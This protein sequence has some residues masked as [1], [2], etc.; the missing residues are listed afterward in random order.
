MSSITKKE[1]LLDDVQIGDQLCVFGGNKVL[2]A[3]TVTRRLKRYFEDSHG[4]RWRYDG[5]FIGS[6][7]WDRSR[8]DRA[9]AE[10]RGQLRRVADIDLIKAFG[11]WNDEFTNEDIHSVADAVRAIIDAHGAKK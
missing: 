5:R 11:G 9:T 3:T 7:D 10:A 4:A 8:I 6:T 1:R 2:R